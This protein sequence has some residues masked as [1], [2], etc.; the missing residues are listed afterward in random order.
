MD[1][2]VSEGPGSDFG[3]AGASR[4]ALL[5]AASDAG[6]LVLGDR[7]TGGV[8]PLLPGASSSAMLHHAPCTVAVV[9]EPGSAARRAA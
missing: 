8:D 7:G 5:D 4:Q 6:L 2:A 3:A 9:P 1:A